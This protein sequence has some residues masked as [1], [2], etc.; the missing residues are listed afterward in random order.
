MSF[1]SDQIRR[2]SRK[3]FTFSVNVKFIFI[4][5]SLSF[6]LAQ[7]IWSQIV[8]FVDQHIQQIRMQ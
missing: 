5:A 1:D 4:F 8:L 6:S 7:N 3:R 2:V